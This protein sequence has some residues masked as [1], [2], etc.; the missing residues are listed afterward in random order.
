MAKEAKEAKEG[1][2]RAGDKAGDKA[3]VEKA[4]ALDTALAP[5]ERQYG[6]G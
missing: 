5:V 2:D 6:K 1:F 4:K 3:R